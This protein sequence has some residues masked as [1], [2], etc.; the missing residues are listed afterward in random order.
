MCTVQVGRGELGAK[1]ALD[2]GSLGEGVE[3]IAKEGGGGVAACEED[4][5]EFGADA[6][7]GKGRGLG[8]EGVEE[9]GA[10]GGGCGGGAA[11]NGSV[12]EVVDEICKA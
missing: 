7:A 2:A 5:E 6:L 3:D 10:G 9:D 12:D 1:A 8:E 11:D 4:V